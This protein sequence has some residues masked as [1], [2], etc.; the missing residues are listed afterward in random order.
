[1]NTLPVY[2]RVTY[3]L[4]F[5]IALGFLVIYAQD[6]LK[7]VV[8]SVLFAFLLVRPT[9]W[10]ERHRF[11]SWLAAMVSVIGLMLITVGLAWFMFT[12]VASFADNWEMMD[13]SARGIPRRA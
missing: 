12:Q 7:P 3:F 2:V 13:T 4:V 9:G 1:M 5:L 6:V 11:P 10:M 8:F